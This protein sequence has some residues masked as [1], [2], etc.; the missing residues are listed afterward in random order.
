MHQLSD[1]ILELN[2]LIDCI[3]INSINKQLKLIDKIANESLPNLQFL[4]SL[5]QKRKLNAPGFGNCVDGLIYELLYNSPDE[6]IQKILK[7]EF[8]DGVINLSSKSHINYKALQLLLINHDFQGA[9]KLTQEKLCELAGI[10]PYERKWLYFTDINSLPIQDL[11]IIDNLWKVHSR[12]KF[13]FSI[14]K[15]IWNQNN[16]DWNELWKKLGW[17]KDTRLSRYPEEFIWD[18]SAPS[19]HLPLFNQLRGV[20]SLLYLFNHPAWETKN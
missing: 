10:M 11:H 12:N 14:Q 4:L 17:Q 20:Q 16:R 19:G 15:E 18:L 13:G 1:Q 9:D 5:L 3:D 7:E 8:P 2:N 6:N